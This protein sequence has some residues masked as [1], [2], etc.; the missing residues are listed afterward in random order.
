M[1]AVLATG[2]SMLF[3][4]PLFRLGVAACKGLY[5]LV[6]NLVGWPYM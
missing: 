2:V 5:C 3:L 6:A 4:A 1:E